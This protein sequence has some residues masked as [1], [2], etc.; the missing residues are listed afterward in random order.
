MKCPA[1]VFFRQQFQ[2]LADPG[3][4]SFP[5]AGGSDFSQPVMAKGAFAPVTPPGRIIG[6]NQAGGQIAVQGQPV[7]IRSR[8]GFKILTDFTPV[9]TGRAFSFFNSPAEFKQ[10]LFAFKQH[11]R[12]K[13]CQSPGQFVRVQTDQDLGNGRSADR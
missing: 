3:N 8:Q 12:I 4:R 7:E 2:V 11:R 5:I 13:R 6:Q 10:R 9:D 1:V